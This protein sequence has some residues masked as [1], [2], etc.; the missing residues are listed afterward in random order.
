MER[1]LCRL[2]LGRDIRARLPTRRVDACRAVAILRRR[3]SIGL[4]RPA[5]RVPS[6][7]SPPRR[8][9]R[10][11]PSRT[12]AMTIDTWSRIAPPAA[13]RSAASSVNVATS[14][15]SCCA[16]ALM[17]AVA[18]RIS[19]AALTTT[20]ALACAAARSA[21][22]CIH[23]GVLW[24]AKRLSDV[25]APAISVERS[26][27]SATCWTTLSREAARL[28]HE[29]LGQDLQQDELAG[30]WL[31]P[32]DVVSDGGSQAL[33]RIANLRGGS[34]DLCSNV[35]RG[36]RDRLRQIREPAVGHTRR[37]HPLAHRTRRHPVL[38][39]STVPARG[40]R[41]RPAPARATPAPG[42]GPARAVTGPRPG[43]SQLAAPIAAGASPVRGFAGTTTAIASLARGIAA[44][45]TFIE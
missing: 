43:R 3:G 5:R 19:V 1:R 18:V 23:S 38:D 35:R 34:I 30:V 32:I 8:P 11:A 16:A 37:G 24:S 25:I 40:A 10:R 21:A 42:S 36:V 15:L 27:A 4:R 9:R 6:H 13:T 33:Q 31:Q 28:G 26:V 20:L 39:H 7:G 41:G 22:S 2:S 14:V 29:R 44:R 12:P 45:F 17:L